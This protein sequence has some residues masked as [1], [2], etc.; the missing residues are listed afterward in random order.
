MTDLYFDIETTGLKPYEHKVLTIQLKE[1]ND[2][3]LWKEW[4]EKQEL[5]LILNFI[6]YL[7][8]VGHSTSIY[9]YNTLKFD[10]PFISARL[11]RPRAL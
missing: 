1:G 11:N 9:G 3:I 5:S 7:K 8:G 6:E 10:V 4:E 2:I